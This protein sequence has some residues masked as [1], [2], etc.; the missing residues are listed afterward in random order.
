M[1][2]NAWLIP[3]SLVKEVGAKQGVGSVRGTPG[4]STTN[5]TD[6]RG[7]KQLIIGYFSD[8]HDKCKI[9]LSELGSSRALSITSLI[10]GVYRLVGSQYV[11]AMSVH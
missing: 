4:A 1:W 2:R 11:R 3:L 10:C 7:Y 6:D 5:K 8:H 9:A